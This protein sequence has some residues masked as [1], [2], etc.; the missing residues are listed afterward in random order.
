MSK[1]EME[2]KLAARLQHVAFVA[3]A[4]DILGCASGQGGGMDF[5][6][7]LQTIKDGREVTRGGCAIH[8]DNLHILT[9]E[10]LLAEDWEVVEL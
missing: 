10:D 5:S 7:A 3:M 4:R 2:T 1:F 6:T 9:P 8:L